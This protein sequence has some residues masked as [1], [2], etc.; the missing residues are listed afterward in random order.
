MSN[1][2]QAP[3][4]DMTGE[5]SLDTS[6]DL[7]TDHHVPMS[8]MPKTRMIPISTGKKQAN[9]PILAAIS[10]LK[11]IIAGTRKLTPLHTR[12]YYILSS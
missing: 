10:L 2:Q 7:G 12:S 3:L 11:T 6:N 5:V 8:R 9:R 4:R 1:D